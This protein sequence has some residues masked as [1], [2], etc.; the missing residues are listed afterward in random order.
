VEYYEVLGL[1]QEPFSDTANPFFLYS[2]DEHQD[3]LH[4]LEISVRLGRGLNLIL[5]DVGTGKTTL[6][7]ALEH[8]L[9]Q[10]QSFQLGAIYDPTFL[11]EEEF[12]NYILMV[13]GM[14]VKP[15][16]TFHQRRE[17]FREYLM[18]N[19]ADGRTFVLIID[20]GQKLSDQNMETLRAFLNFQTPKQRLL[21][22]VIFSQLEI[23]EEIE[24]NS[25]FKERINL[26]YIL[27]P[28]TR[29][30]THRMI[31]YRL[32]KAGLDDGRSLFSPQAIDVI[33][34]TTQGY[35]RKIIL[36]CQEAIEELI[37][38]EKPEVDDEMMESIIRRRK[39]MH[40][41]MDDY[42]EKME[43]ERRLEREEEAAM[44]ALSRADEWSLETE[45]EHEFPAEFVDEER[46][47]KGKPRKKRGLFGWLFRG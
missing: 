34:N 47:K 28:L 46:E 4:R 18:S 3:C 26:M 37:V 45:S 1:S 21:N 19:I 14:Q 30:D 11:T 10:D 7:M 24:R 22:M 39:D 20:E 13:M 6:A 38:Q 16:L 2:S 36:L 12:L 40:V 15:G 17:A 31:T 44:E 35:P 5:G 25:G 32:Q 23:L 43:Q 33:F 29:D 9:L 41:L 42:R 27:K 8:N